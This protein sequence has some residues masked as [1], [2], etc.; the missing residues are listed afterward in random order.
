VRGGDGT[1]GK[2]KTKGQANQNVDTTIMEGSI[3]TTGV[4][5]GGYKPTPIE[6]SKIF[7]LRVCKVYSPSPALKFIKSY[8]LYRKTLKMYTIFTFCFSFCGTS[9]PR[10]AGPAPRH[11]NP[12]HCKILSTP[13][14][15]TLF[16]CCSLNNGQDNMGAINS[17]SCSLCIYSDV[18]LCSVGGSE[19]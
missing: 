11:V 3:A 9:S 2:R 19:H 17:A 4:P 13:M 12:L 16:F 8:I 10:P 5:R 14:I 1:K 15:A 6:S 7:V 18:T